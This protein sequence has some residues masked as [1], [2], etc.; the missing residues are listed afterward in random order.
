MTRI[1]STEDVHPRD[2]VACWVD[3]SCDTIVHVIA[4]PAAITRSSPRFALIRQVRYAAQ[5]ILQW[6]RFSRVRRARSHSG[7]AIVYARDA[8]G[9]SRFRQS[10]RT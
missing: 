2:R 7:L 9:R 3:G 4:N 6:P 1:W 8:I 10:G 5:P